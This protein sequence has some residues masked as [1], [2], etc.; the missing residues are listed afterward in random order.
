MGIM[1][2]TS[3]DS[4]DVSVVEITDERISLVEFVSEEYPRELR[5]KIKHAETLRDVSL[6]NR[7]V[8]EFFSLVAKKAKTK[9]FCVGTHGQ[10]IYH[11]TSH[12]PV[13]ST[14]QIGYPECLARD[15]GC[16]VVSDFRPR[17]IVLGG[18][19]APLTPY[20]DLRF[21]GDKS[22]KLVLNIGGISNI[23]VLGQGDVVGFDVG[24]GNAPLDRLTSLLTEGNQ[25]YDIDGSLAAGGQ[26][27]EEILKCLIDEDQF[28]KRL[29]PKSTGVESYGDSFVGRLIELHGLSQNLLATVTEFVA[30]CIAEEAKKFEGNLILCGGGSQ[31]SYL[32]SRISA[33]MGRSV[34]LIDSYGV[35]WNAR[36]S[37]AFAVMAHDLLCGLDTSLTSV[38]GAKVSAPLGRITLP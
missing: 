21:F 28:I 38:T 36:E 29:P 16:L 30:H 22:P 7:E 11:H 26:V 10:T 1:S 24:P 31:N 33:K 19:G 20:A 4:V 32:R 35:P 9:V 5:S 2:G 6:L 17:D 37:M 12:D 8:G 15:L 27:E 23:T 18:E 25:N 13:K 34:E 14:L 3:V